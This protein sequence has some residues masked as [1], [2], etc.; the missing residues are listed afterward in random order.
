MPLREDLLQPIAGENPSGP[1]LYYD[2]VF[3][4]IKEA[5]REDE[6]PLP[7]DDW[8]PAQLKKADF[9]Q[10]VKLAGDTLAAKSKDLRLAG[11][12]IEA[13]MRLEGLPILVPGIDLVLGIQEQFWDT[14]HPVIE[15]GDIEGRSFAVE[16][17]VRQAALA[18]EVLALS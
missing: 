18:A 8:A 14:F 6:E 17:V 12:L 5:R 13:Q 1:N 15:D 16:A 4:Q 9:R 10:V 11:F 7:G 3:D 2:K